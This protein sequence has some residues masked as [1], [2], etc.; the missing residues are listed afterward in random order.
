MFVMRRFRLSMAAT[1]VALTLAASTASAQ[2]SNIF[3]V[4]DSL[5]DAG[6]FKPV[7][8]PGT[9]LFT[10]NPGPIWAQVL[11]QRYGLTAIPANQGGTNYAQGGARV[12]GLPGVPAAPPTGTAVPIATQVNQFL[13]TGPA[14]PNALYGVW[15]GAND[16]LYNLG[17][18]QAG[19]ITP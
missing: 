14:D 18:L 17:A 2:Y 8:P 6:S 4:G 3:F 7:L 1:A 15:G 5:T 9:G 16:I 12:T 19:A 13:L 10:T 11:A